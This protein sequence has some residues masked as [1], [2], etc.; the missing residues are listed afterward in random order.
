LPEELREVLLYGDDHVYTISGTNRAGRM[1]SFE[2]TFEGV[3][4]NLERRYQETQSDYMRNEIEKYMRKEVC[5]GC[6]GARL[7]S[8]SLSVTVDGKTISQVADLSIQDCFGAIKELESDND[9]LSEKEKLIGTQIIKE[10]SV[11]LEFLNAVGL[12][13]LTLSRE[14]ATLAGGEA[15]RIRLASQIGTGLTGVLYVLDEPSIGLHQR[16]NDRLIKTLKNLRDLGNSVLV[17]EHDRDIMMASDYLIDIGPGAGKMGGLVVAEGTPQ[18]VAGN[19]KSLTGKYLSGR[20]KIRITDNEKAK[21]GGVIKLTGASLH[22]LKNLALTIPLNKLVVITGVSG[23]GKSTLIHE[24]LY[25]AVKKYLGHEITTGRNYH[26]FSG[27]EQIKKVSLIDQ[28]PIG[29]TPR[30]NPVTYTKTFD[31][32]RQIFASVGDSRIRGYKPGRFSFNVKGG[33]CEACQGDGQVKIEM[34][35][36]SD[37]YITCDVCHGSRYNSET[38]EVRYKGKT[39]SDVLHMTVD[40]GVEFFHAHSTLNDKLQ[41]LKKVGLG[42]I[43]LGQPAPTLSGGEAQRI[44]LA[45]ELSVRTS[46]Q[47]LYLL[48]EPTTG[49]HF[50]DLKKLLFVLKALVEQGNTVVVIEHNLD[51]IKNADWLVD[52]GPEGGEAGGKIVA[53]GTPFEVSKV[54]GSYTGSYLTK[55]ISD[56]V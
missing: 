3:M 46:G 49:L 51:V 47:T 9:K 45:K 56:S 4:A 42:Y 19:G 54:K 5:S 48:D 28:S 40:E 34:Q 23:S 31:Y 27:G 43:E 1:T 14:A 50:E 16:D 26:K 13:Y 12:E 24:T 38:L 30:S 33:R 15:Q 20:M 6:K 37:V 11:R 21:E 53:T 10:I 17:V 32:I 2:D 36:M 52:L 25:K 55:V 8:T 22:N 29:R 41:T 18:A 35:F 39:I 44:K 7:K